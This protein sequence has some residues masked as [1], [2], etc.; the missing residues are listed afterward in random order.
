MTD[1]CLSSLVR[2]SVLTFL[3]WWYT[4]L[5]Q[6]LTLHSAPPTITCNCLHEVKTRMSS[7]LLKLNRNKTQVVSPKV[8]LQQTKNLLI[9]MRFAIWYFTSYLSSKQLFYT[10]RFWPLL[11]DA[12]AETL[13]R[14]SVTTSVSDFQLQCV[15][16][17]YA[18]LLTHSDLW[19][20][21]TP[22]YKAP[23][24]HPLMLWPLVTYLG[25]PVTPCC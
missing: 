8:W 20:H 3:C 23:L 17:L 25:K 2:S 24:A 7:N 19:E 5:S 16:N 21:I 13:L 15:Q 11:I 12:A 18:R 4:S 9:D 6:Y 22:T 10:F 1:S 14:A